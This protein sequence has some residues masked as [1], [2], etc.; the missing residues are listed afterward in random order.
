ERRRD[1]NKE[2]PHSALGD[3]TPSEFVRLEEEKL[4][5]TT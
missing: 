5:A 3:L 1:Y 2:R 4:V